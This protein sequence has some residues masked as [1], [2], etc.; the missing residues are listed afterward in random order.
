VRFF[1]SAK[2]NTE[3]QRP[4]KPGHVAP[5]E[6]VQL[7]EQ[8]AVMVDVRESHEWE[9]GRVAG[10][11]HLPLMHL[12]SRMHELPKGRKIVVACRSGGRSAHAAKILHKAG[13]DVVNLRGGLHAWH[14]AG[15]PLVGKHG[16]PGRLR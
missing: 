13:H 4:A 7:L 1:R 8:G 3:S 11:R 15:L 6:A 9:A 2:P 5:H 10:A 14:L 16:K 12:G